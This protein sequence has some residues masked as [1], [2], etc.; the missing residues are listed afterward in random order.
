MGALDQI[1]LAWFFFSLIDKGLSRS[2]DTAHPE[3]AE[4]SASPSLPSEGPGGMTPG[5]TPGW[6]QS[7]YQECVHRN[8]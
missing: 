1:W 7:G 5:M 2:C 8:A 4:E 6:L 3:L